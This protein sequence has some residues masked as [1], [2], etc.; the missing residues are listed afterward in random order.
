MRYTATAPLDVRL[1]NIAASAV[2]AG[3]FV[4]LLAAAGWWAV[5]H[6]AFSITR[7]VMRGDLTHNNPVAL[8]ANVAP[9]LTGN[10]FTINL[11]HA[12]TAFEQVPWVRLAEVRRQFPNGLGV[13][14]QEHVPLAYWGPESGTLMVNTYGEV[15][16]ASQSQSELENLP[17]PQPVSSEGATPGAL[18]G[19]AKVAASASQSEGGEAQDDAQAPSAIDYAQL[20]RLAGPQGSA[21]Q[22]LEMLHSANDALAGL[23][24]KVTS[25]TWR[26]RGSWLAVLD[27]GARMELGA[28]QPLAV[29]ERLDRF[30]RV[31]GK[32]LPQYRRPVGALEYA[33]LRYGDGFALKLRGIGTVQPPVVQPP[34]PSQ[35]ARN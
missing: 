12:R 32:V 25:L 7:I 20:P 24:M 11:A 16:D 2:F 18:G 17:P 26:D 4:L 13:M 9:Y 22:V 30:V 10:F 27:N 14:L 15:F 5:R 33:D 28:G 8:R 23:G 21:P 31:L 6:P 29:R 34:G 1:M 35:P 3:V 19:A